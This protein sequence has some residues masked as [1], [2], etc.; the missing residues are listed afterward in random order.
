MAVRSAYRQLSCL[1]HSLV[2]I[3]IEELTNIIK[4]SKFEIS[5]N[6]NLTYVRPGGRYVLFK[7]LFVV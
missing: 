7:P 6:N 3:M 2:R 5:K 1:F 4:N